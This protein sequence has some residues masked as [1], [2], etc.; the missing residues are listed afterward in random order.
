M[1]P[2]SKS[3]KVYVTIFMSPRGDIKKSGGDTKKKTYGFDSAEAAAPSAMGRV[4]TLR[5]KCDPEPRER[6]PPR[7][8][9]P[10]L[11]NNLGGTPN[12]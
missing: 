2:L 7:S 10:E 12:P 3:L 5:G 1:S 6:R 4:F 11:C 9:N 8:R